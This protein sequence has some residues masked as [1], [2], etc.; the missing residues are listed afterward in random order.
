MRNSNTIVVFLQWGKNG[1]ADVG[2][3]LCEKALE[4]CTSSKDELIAISVGIMDAEREKRYMELPV[5][6]V[7]HLETAKTHDIASIARLS[8][9]SIER[10]MP[11]IVLFG[12]TKEGRAIAPYVAGLLETGLTADC[13]SLTLESD[14][15]LTQVRPAFG[16]AVLATIKS[17]SLPEMATVRPG[18]FANNNV[19]PIHPPIL[20]R[21][22]CDESDN[23]QLF[24]QSLPLIEDDI[25]IGKVPFAIVLG[26]GVPDIETAQK[27]MDWAEKL[28]GTYACSRKL[29]ERGWFPVSRQIGLS[30]ASS[31]AEL[32]ILLGVSGSVQFQ[33][34]IKRVKR[35]VA[36]NTDPDA[37][38]FRVAHS[39][40]I[41]DVRKIAELIV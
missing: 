1:I 3:E 28:G 17:L 40:I 37:P 9:S 20:E 7:I 31:E 15:T 4:W 33:A 34:G 14:G 38:I 24:L 22:M 39:A 26:G 6:R 10:I 5:N 21:Y 18:I 2:L 41:S 36:V 23:A 19:R 25:C 12:A 11:N 29:V 30:G 35:I 32:L 8:A 27:L 16:E 13:T